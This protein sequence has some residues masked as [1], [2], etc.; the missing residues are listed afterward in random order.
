MVSKRERRP[1]VQWQEQDFHAP[2]RTAIKSARHVPAP[3]HNPPQGAPGSPL[4]DDSAATRINFA[5]RTSHKRSTA[6]VTKER[7]SKPLKAESPAWRIGVEDGLFPGTVLCNRHGALDGRDQLWR[8]VDAQSIWDLQESDSMPDEEKAALSLLCY[9]D[10]K[11]KAS[12]SSSEDV[13]AAGSQG[14][15]EAGQPWGAQ[16]PTHHDAP[17]QAAS[18]ASE[19][20][21]IISQ[22]GVGGRKRKRASSNDDSH[23]D[24]DQALHAPRS[25]RRQLFAEPAQGSCKSNS[26]SLLLDA[27][28]IWLQQ[29]DVDS[30]N[31]MLEEEDAAPELSEAGHGML[32]VHKAS[33]SDSEMQME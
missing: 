12:S 21:P 8:Y 3:R 10:P 14:R 1:K 26:G 23:S 31:D 9:W 27:I 2:A 4:S 25:K 15:A 6:P 28:D 17:T 7:A 5:P 20:Q 18:A 13:K 22:A 19:Q 16:S 32:C 24:C 30:R 33:S 11:G 29:A